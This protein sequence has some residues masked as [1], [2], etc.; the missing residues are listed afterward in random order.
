M[1]ENM[2]SVLDIWNFFRLWNHPANVIKCALGVQDKEKPRGRMRVKA[3]R[4]GG[5]S[6][7]SCCPRCREGKSFKNK[8]SPAS[9]AFGSSRDIKI[10]GYRR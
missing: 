10:Q 4:R 8:W 6:G 1:R 5:D 2:N 7:D 3:G 9:K